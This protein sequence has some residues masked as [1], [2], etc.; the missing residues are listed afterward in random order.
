MV[1]LRISSLFVKFTYI[2]LNNIQI[3][4]VQQQPPDATIVEEAPRINTEN[5]IHAQ[6]SRIHAQNSSFQELF[7]ERRELFDE[8][9]ELF[10]EREKRVRRICSD[11]SLSETIVKHPVN[12]REFLINYDYKL[13]WCNIF[14]SASTTWMYNFVALKGHSK[15]DVDRTRKKV[16]E[17]AR[18]NDYP[19]PSS[20]ELNGVLDDGNF[21]SFIVVREPFER[22]LSSYSDKILDTKDHFYDGVRCAMK[23]GCRPKFSDFV[24]FIIRE[25]KVGRRLD[26]HWH[27]YAT[28]CSPCLAEYDFILHFENLHY[29][30]TYFI[31]QVIFKSQQKGICCMNKLV[32]DQS[33]ILSVKNA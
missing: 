1:H 17:F 21:T 8:R 13:A 19:R 15:K 18:K 6:N 31:E 28:F 33:Y 4:E 5:R 7:D 11:A 3:V 24:R 10:E 16:V 32:Y 29:E 14:K 26:E 27:P 20:E 30:E 2:L 9:R 12:S 25:V 22:L 23:K